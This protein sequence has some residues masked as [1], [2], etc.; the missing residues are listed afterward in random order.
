MG[1]RDDTCRPGDQVPE[2]PEGPV[3][4]DRCWRR[5]LRGAL[6]C[7]AVL[8]ALLLTTDRLAGT[9]TAG[10]SVLWLGLAVLLFVVLLPAQVSAGDDWLAS[11]TLLGTRRVHTDLLVSVRCRDGVAQR[12][13]L[14]D[15][16]GNRV[17]LDPR[18]LI[19]NPELW[20]RLDAGARRS[21]A[22]GALM[23]GRTALRR[24]SARVDGE[25]ARTVFR[26][27]DLD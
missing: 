8:L 27:S 18:V 24:I 19:A 9:L 15:A 4:Y 23:C 3:A 2:R 6:R 20:Y 10:R 14:R 1:H 16:L 25:T 21:E 22:V 11:R 26:M 17:E 7:S 5:E 12:L 13:L